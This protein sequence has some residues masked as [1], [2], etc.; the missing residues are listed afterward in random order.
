MLAVTSVN[1]VDNVGGTP[2]PPARVS[3]SEVRQ[4]YYMAELGD[5]EEIAVMLSKKDL[6]PGFENAA[7]D[8]LLKGVE[9]CKSQGTPCKVKRLLALFCL[10]EDVKVDIIWKCQDMNWMKPVKD[11]YETGEK[12]G[13]AGHAAKTIL[14]VMERRMQDKGLPESKVVQ[15]KPQPIARITLKPALVA[16]GGG[17][18]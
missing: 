2:S 3:A 12:T 7:K 9:T 10:P 6:K 17:R 18:V 11:W 15:L 13:A 8:A 1:D 14:E 5:V 4:L 16:M